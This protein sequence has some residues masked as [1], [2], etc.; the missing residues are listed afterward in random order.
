MIS[1]KMVFL[2]G[3][4]CASHHEMKINGLF[5]TEENPY[6]ASERLSQYLSHLIHCADDK[7]EGFDVYQMLAFR[8]MKHW[9]LDFRRMQT[10][11]PLP[12]PES[13]KSC[14]K[15]LV[16]W[17]SSDYT[18]AVVTVVIIGLLQTFGIT[19][20]LTEVMFAYFDPDDPEN[21]DSA[22]ECQCGI[23]S[24]GDWQSPDDVMF[25]LLAFLFCAMI[26]INL[27]KQLHIIRT[28]GFNMVL[29]AEQD[30]GMRPEDFGLVGIADVALLQTGVLINLYALLLCFLGSFFLIYASEGGSRGFD[31]VLNALALFFLVELDDLL[32][33][34]S[35]YEDVAKYAKMLKE[36]RADRPVPA[37]DE[38][39][40]CRLSCVKRYVACANWFQMVLKVVVYT[41]AV[42]MPFAVAVCW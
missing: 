35:D 15:K 26:S 16:A 17:V 7:Q 1:P 42:V 39:A 2:G 19:L 9:M 30:G 36:Q 10:G 37:F 21:D 14:W 11:K 23:D 24:L 25:K 33:E 40:C 3:E 28:N 31:M 22:A 5:D 32:V 8:R 29:A 20:I 18:Q 27:G 41:A 4:R 13:P 6:N 12:G 38:T 34:D